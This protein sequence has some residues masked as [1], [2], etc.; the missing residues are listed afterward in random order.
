MDNLKIMTYN[1]LHIDDNPLNCW[2]DRKQ[3]IKNLIGRE[4]PDIIGTQECLFS[5]IKDLIK[6]L[7]EYDWI[8]MGRLG[9]SQDD[10]MAIYYKKDRFNLL[11]YN[12]FWLSDMPNTI[13]SMTF[14]NATPRMVTWA[15]FK[16]MNTGCEFYHMNTHLDYFCEEARIKGAK[17]ILQK[18]RE[19]EGNLPIFLTGDFNTDVNTEP[20]SIL[21]V[22]GEFAD[23]WDLSLQHINKELGTMND[24][25]DFTG[26]D[27]RIDWIL[28]KG[29]V[30]VNT[31]KIVD[32]CINKKFPSDHFPVIASCKI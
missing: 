13:G 12:H 17:L 16:D 22:G 7:P 9:G 18:A 24:F 20:F 32:D 10:Y 4:V 26:G 19:L 11:D 30:R 21:T 28:A 25:V 29:N 23:T 14:G 8:G 5:Q 6:L 3:L 1:M 2:E 15:K 27:R 31:I